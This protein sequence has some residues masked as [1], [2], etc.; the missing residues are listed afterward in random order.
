MKARKN[1][2]AFDTI[3]SDQRNRIY[4]A[5]NKVMSEDERYFEKIISMSVQQVITNFVNN[6][7]ELSVQTVSDFIFN[8]MKSDYPLK[9]IEE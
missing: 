2:L 4:V 7:E 5:R 1:T 8:N 6:V 9:K 3:L